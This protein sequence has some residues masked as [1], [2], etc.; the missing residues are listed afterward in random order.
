MQ[1]SQA[2]MVP[3]RINKVFEK[4]F[5]KDNHFGGDLTIR[6]YRIVN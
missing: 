5:L 4:S 2:E 3:V 1:V 6:G